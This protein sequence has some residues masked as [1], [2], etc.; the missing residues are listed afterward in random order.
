MIKGGERLEFEV[1]R[2]NLEEVKRGNKISFVSPECFFDE[3]QKNILRLVS[4]NIVMEIGEGP[5]EILDIAYFGKK[6]GTLFDIKGKKGI[7]E[8][9]NS[10]YFRGE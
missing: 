9:V 7:Y 10:D 2:S 6:Y 5:Y 8:S 1:L 4:E 3:K